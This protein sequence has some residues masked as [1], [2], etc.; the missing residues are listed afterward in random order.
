MKMKVAAACAS[1]LAFSLAA[2]DQKTIASVLQPYVDRHEL[3]GAV[4]LVVSKDSFL[5]LESVGYSDVSAKKSMPTDAI[6]WIASISKPITA[7]AVMM[8]VD[9]GKIRLDDPVQK[10]LPEFS[11]RI[12][13]VTDDRAAVRTQK[14]QHTI[15]VRNLLSHTSGMSFSSSIE[16]PTLDSFPLTVRVQSYSLELLRYEPGSDYQYSNAGINTAGR[17][18]EAVSGMRYEEFLQKRLF[19]PLGMKDTTFW[20][21]EAQLTRLAKSYRPNDTATDLE[22]TTVTQLRY[23]LTDHVH[24][25]PMPAGGLFSTANDLGKFCQLFLNG[26]MVAGKRY[27]SEAAIQEMTRNQLDPAIQPGAEGIAK[28][29]RGYGLGWETNASGAFG[30]GGAYATDLRID[31]K[32]GFATVWLVQH[33]GFPG[34]GRKSREAFEEAAAKQF[35]P[36]ANPAARSSHSDVDT[37]R[38]H[39]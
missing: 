19:G 20:P 27:V 24:R 36:N 37:K 16:K 39:D 3:A 32:R 25:Y 11:P 31:P 13:A 10:Y 34:E 22:E 38:F 28:A 33:A 12:M 1:L 18:I 7:A 30:H 8:L 14:P 15:T 2:A 17:I 6:F 21:T 5:S 35:I 29:K 4:A 26:G 23:P 9:E